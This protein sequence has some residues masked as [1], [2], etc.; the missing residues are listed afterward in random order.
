MAIVLHDGKYSKIAP[1][2]NGWP[3]PQMHRA[4]LSRTAATGVALPE[5]CQRDMPTLR[6]IKGSV[7]ASGG[8]ASEIHS[9]GSESLPHMRTALKAGIVLFPLVIEAHPSAGSRLVLDDDLLAQTRSDSQR[10][11]ILDTMS[12]L[13]PAQSMV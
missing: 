4:P 8:R 9:L 13:I 6:E 2:S 10:P 5:S 12:A 1:A 11:M 3:G 7:C